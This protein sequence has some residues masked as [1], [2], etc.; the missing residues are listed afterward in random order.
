MLF[1]LDYLY[2][3]TAHLSSIEAML[4]DNT[5]PMTRY[6]GQTS[7]YLCAFGFC[8]MLV[9]IIMSNYHSGLVLVAGQTLESSL[10]ACTGKASDLGQKKRAPRG[11][12]TLGSGSAVQ[13]AGAGL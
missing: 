5:D 9:E 7:S 11:E 6:S 4:A 8:R 1:M 13:R 10:N 3:I 2:H 12:G